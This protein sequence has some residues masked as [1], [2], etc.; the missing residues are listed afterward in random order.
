MKAIRRKSV[1]RLC[2]YPIDNPDGFAIDLRA[3]S[4]SSSCD[5]VAQYHRGGE[6]LQR[7]SC[8]SVSG[9]SKSVA[10]LGLL[11]SVCCTTRRDLT[12]IASENL[13]KQGESSNECSQKE[14]GKKGVCWGF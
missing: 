9:W 2:R 13:I 7:R 4:H 1:D 6:R 10:C 5:S 14:R 8:S 12:A 3:L 11:G